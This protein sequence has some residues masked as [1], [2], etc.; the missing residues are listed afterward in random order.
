MQWFLEEQRRNIFLFLRA[1]TLA[2]SS[3]GQT[4]PETDNFAAEI[5]PI[6]NNI[7]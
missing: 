2:R 5:Y 3:R 7:Y 4:R 6:A 1:N